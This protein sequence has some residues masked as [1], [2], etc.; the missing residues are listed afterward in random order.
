MI[1]SFDLKQLV[2]KS[3]IKPNNE[4]LPDRAYACP[5]RAWINGEFSEAF[6]RLLW[7]LSA[8]EWTDQDNDCD[9]FARAAAWFSALLHHRTGER[10]KQALAFGEF[11][12]TRKS[13]VQ[14][15]GISIICLKENGQYVLVFW[16]PQTRSFVD[17][18]PEELASCDTYRF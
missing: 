17:L 9:D 13:D 12:Y 16:E 8:H 1:D 7:V 11:W 3:G 18:T 5:D 4:L 2:W 15:H 14:N 10:K 6:A